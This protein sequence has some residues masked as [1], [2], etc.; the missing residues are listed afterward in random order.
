MVNLEMLD[1]ALKKTTDNIIEQYLGTMSPTMSR[2]E[3]EV[4]F[5]TLSSFLLNFQDEVEILPYDEKVLVWD[6][7]KEHYSYLEKWIFE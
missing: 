3:V 5:S 1:K 4:A 2:A 7:I 6:V